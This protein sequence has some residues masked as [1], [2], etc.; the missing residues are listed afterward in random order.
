M[1]AQL[2]RMWI[3]PFGR[4]SA[5]ETRS[6]MTKPTEA[7]EERSAIAVRHARPRD[8]M[9]SRVEALPISRCDVSSWCLGNVTNAPGRG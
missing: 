9:S 3:P 1:P 2:R 4:A 6:G 8:M 5:L 7:A